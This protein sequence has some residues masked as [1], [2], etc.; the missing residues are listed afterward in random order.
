MKAAAVIPGNANSLNFVN[1]SKPRIAD[2]E[3]LVRVIRVGLDGT[4]REIGKGN[5]GKAPKGS[6]YLIV[7]HESLGVIEKLG[8]HAKNSGFKLGD[9][10][11]A[12]VR[13][14]D[15]CMNCRAGESDM[16]LTGN[17]TERGIK[18]AH[19]YM[20][21]YY[22]EL[23]ANLVRIP[24]AIR[25][26]AVMLEP[27]SIAEKAITQAF[28]AQRRMLWK[29]KTAVVLGT[30]AVGMFAAMLL[31]LRGL[32]VTSV[33]RTP[34]HPIKGRL[35][36][37]MHIR[38]I[39]SK[40]TGIA[41]VPAAVG[42]PIDV[43]VELTGNP[44]VVYDA[45]GMTGP[46]GVTS[47]VSVTGKSY[48]STVDLAALNYKLVLGN[49]LVVGV[50]NSN[51]HHFEQGVRDMAKIEKMH[52]GL[53]ESMITKRVRFDDFNSYGILDDRSQVKVSV[54][55]GGEKRNHSD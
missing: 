48:P 34:K 27:L 5:Y 28:E 3:A 23:P 42:N 10:V 49:R 55:I 17:Y 46:N 32:D 39:N 19:G 52:P 14:P 9:C 45:M 31:R 22:K 40:A 38:H 37:A 35:F 41:S 44:S 21:E 11:V 29:P 30:G 7:G 50:V 13:R 43:V 26:S 15:S 54:E 4:D 6:R 20:T 47:L 16:C 53:L 18:G 12:T 8:Q 51:R 2:D 25:E 24:R 36:K 1:V 33:D